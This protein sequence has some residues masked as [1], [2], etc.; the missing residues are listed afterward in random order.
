[1]ASPAGWRVVPKRPRA[2]LATFP[3]TLAAFAVIVLVGLISG[4]LWDALR[5]RRLLH[6][7]A[8]GVPALEH[9]RWWT[10]VTG[11]VYALQPSGYV[12]ALMVFVILVGFAEWRLGTRTTAIATIAI[13]LVVV[14]VTSALLIP[15]RA[16]GWNWAVD[17][18]HRELTG[19]L[20]GAFGAFA[21]ATVTLRAP[22]RSRIRVVLL[23]YVV[24]LTLYRGAARDV[25]QLLAVGLGLLLGPVLQN[26]APAFARPRM[27]RHEWRMAAAFVFAVSAAIRLVLIIAPSSASPLRPQV[28]Q[29]FDWADLVFGVLLPL[30]LAEGLRRG[31]RLAWQVAM[32]ITVLGVV[33]V[34]AGVIITGTTDTR[35]DID[36]LGA[37][38]A[39]ALLWLT[40]LGVL[41]LGRRA[42]RATPRRDRDMLQRHAPRRG[43][44]CS[45]FCAR[46][47]VAGCLG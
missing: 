9:G 15:L 24:L 43:V 40:Q 19:F 4:T 12:A 18:A 30:V 6:S 36:S 47:V 22:W 17:L 39:D 2:V 21:A 11:S 23:G 34:I 1:M 5:D 35:Y 10:P 20:P 33:T 8:Y 41:W 3:F 32:V 29:G 27:S 42:F 7:V 46:L 26:R 45:T 37:S 28:G 16:T 14:I 31:R 38:I 13:Q 25:E 44:R